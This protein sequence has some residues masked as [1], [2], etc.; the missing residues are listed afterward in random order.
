MALTRITKGVIKPNENYDTHNINS[1]GII[2]A[3]KFVGAIETS[4]A[5]ITGGSITATT[6]TFS[7]NVSIGGT[8]TY[9]DVTNIDSV[10]I[11]T[12]RDGL[13]VLGGGANIVGVVTATGADINGDIDVDGHTNLDNVSIAG[14]TTATGNIIANNKVGIKTD[15]PVEVLDVR[16]SVAF[17]TG[18]GNT[19]FRINDTGFQI[20][21]SYPAWGNL[22]Y[23]INP[24]IKWG[25]LTDV[26][27][28]LYFATG[29]N[30]AETS[31]MS[32]LLADGHGFKVGK[33]GWD[34]VNNT[35]L[36]TEYFRITTG[37][38]VGIGEDDPDELLHIASTGTAKFK[39]T[40]KR[41]SISDGSQYGVIQFEQKDSNTPGVSLEMAALMTDTTNGATALQIKTGTPSTITERVR[42]AS[43]GNVGI[44][45][46]N[47]QKLLDLSA[48][49]PTIGVKATGGNDASLELI[50][51]GGPAID[52][53]ETG[54][55]GFRI[56]Y[57]GGDNRLYFVSGSDTTVNNRLT[58]LRDT[59]NIGIGTDNPLSKLH[60][61]NTNSTVW[62][63]TSAVTDTYGYT[64]YPHE[65]IIDNDVRGTT[66][67]FAG[68]Y[69]NAG[70]DSDGSKVSTARIAAI[71]T[72][73][74][75]A[76]LVFATRGYAS[77]G[78]GADDHKEHLRITSAG[79]VGVG[80]DSPSQRVTSYTAS[81]YC[82]LA[83][84]PGSGIGLGNNG[85]I[86]F[87]TKD[88]G[89]YAKGV[90]D[91][92]ELEFKISGTAKVNITSSG[93]LNLGTTNAL[94]NLASFK[95]LNIGNN[96]ILN[97]GTSAGGYIGFQNNAYL[98][99]A[100][101]WTRMHNDHA[102]SIGMDDGVFYFRHAGAG[103]GNISWKTPL[104][105]EATG[106]LI[107]QTDQSTTGLVLQN[108]VH[109]SILRIEAQA[110]NK[111]SII[112]FAD[113][114][115]GDVG[116][117]DYDHNDNSLAFTV[118]TSERLHIASDGQL[119]HTT[120]KA[121]GYIAIF[122]QAHADNPG[123]VKI[124]SPTNNNLR[125]AALHLAQADSVK[126]VVG[127]VYN[128]TA[129]QA[130]HICSGTGESNSKLVVTTAGNVGVNIVNPSQAK[131]VAQ[132][133]SGMS[134][135]AVKDNTGASISLGGV[136]QPRI[137]MEAGASASDFIL[138]R[139][140]GSSYGSAGWYKT[141]TIQSNGAFRTHKAD[142][143]LRP[144][145]IIG[146]TDIG[147]SDAEYGQFNYADVMAPNGDLGSWV[148][149]GADYHGAAPYPVKCYKI[150]QHEPGNNG[151]RV[152]QIWHDGDANHHYG[153]LYEVRL[154]SW[155]GA[156]SNN[157]F[158][159]ATISCVN[160]M[161]D[162]ISLLCYKSTDGIWIRPSTIWGG[163]WIR[164]A[165]W[166]GSGRDRGSSYCSV[167]NGGALASADI[168][169]MG[170]TI[171]GSI[172]KRLYPYVDTYSP[173]QSYGGRDI[174]D[175][176]DF[177]AG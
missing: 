97:A 9:E 114:A 63:F 19:I 103:T 135:A 126:W 90:L 3:T 140:T 150:A 165:G 171:P 115:D 175:G 17:K 168:N 89:S 144:Y 153:A 36:S 32:M 159:S 78:G 80:T 100:G 38:K 177:V 172:D 6:G 51:T 149:L 75:K 141:L 79:K 170:G 60:L 143:N 102:S 147:S 160:G 30:T 42:I 94:S 161:V 23:D 93:N 74:Y 116:M 166:D 117:I 50:E 33:S 152:Y 76:D 88:L 8:L 120:N 125:P 127:Q 106:R 15:S 48:A 65:L 47:P 124:N 138:Y 112:H 4:N 137:L 12:A 34:G 68:I 10:G 130:F 87:G 133:A 39:L 157:Y 142:S 162:D 14:V 72:G 20:N 104:T 70:A 58:I 26:G 139:A 71:D 13:K 56:R 73:D 29:G 156:D 40:D 82:F 61:A 25:W 11:I 123:T 62:P 54:S 66:G 169:G 108:T 146:G 83:N 18:I 136:T 163:L 84:G 57:D 128:S 113:G 155:G 69:F 35:N 95:H 129:S 86:V 107:T 151:T 145:P 118:N 67:S 16:G 52:F 22:N 134:I 27:D 64:P 105:I 132:T 122:N 49:N 121:S 111:N 167:K 7:G 109:D 28:H 154:N 46:T 174:E 98:S 41:T 21:Q 110:A 1:T 131:L 55:A 53:G 173:G 99:A 37:G 77:G 101:N 119:T 91:G 158:T 96:L 43:N 85:A 5:T 45:I 31:Q 176:N 44:G 164:R 81:G 92:S 148:Y 59:G 2:T 24:L